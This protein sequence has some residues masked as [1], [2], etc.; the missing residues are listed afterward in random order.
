VASN[1]ASVNLN[2]V[3]MFV[4]VVS[5]GSFAHA[6]RRLGM[7]A[8][9]ASDRVR[10]LEDQ[11]GIRLLHRSTR[12]LTLTDAGRKFYDECSGHIDALAQSAKH[13]ADDGHGPHGTIKVAVFADF[14]DYFLMDWTAEFFTLYPRVQVEFYLSDTPPDMIG[15]GIDVALRTGTSLEPNLVARQIGASCASLVASP[16]YLAKRGHPRV[17]EEL[18]NHD[19]ISLKTVSRPQTWS[20]EGP[21]GRVEIPAT[22]CFAANTSPSV[23]KAALAGLGIALLPDIMTQSHI[24]AKK[25][26]T[27]LPKYRMEET[28]LYITYSTRQQQSK[29]AKVFI[30][31]LFSKLKGGYF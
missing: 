6:A 2:D 29:A 12:R 17:I 8:N 31:F 28:G 19:C 30:D 1:L 20:L 5:A 27:V 22:G 21:E 24:N 25:L 26:I 13:I 10:K 18:Q 23:L 16:A 3:L 9:T 15:D 14:F 11:L 4:E 7:P